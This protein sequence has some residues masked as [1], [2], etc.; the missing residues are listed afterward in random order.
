[1]VN[2]E[3]NSG[4][5]AR[6]LPRVFLFFIFDTI[7]KFRGTFRGT[8]IDYFTNLCDYILIIK[9]YKTNK[10]SRCQAGLIQ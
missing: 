10:K 4:E 7:L 6:E 8:F 3:K 5:Q 9:K 1:M 2:P